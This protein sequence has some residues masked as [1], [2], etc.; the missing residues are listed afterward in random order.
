MSERYSADPNQLA[1]GADAPHTVRYLIARGFVDV[2]EV[3]VDAACGHGYGSR[4][5]AKVASKVIA[6]DKDKVFASRDNIEFIQADFEKLEE[7]PECD[8]FVSIE[9]IEHLADPQKFLD[10]ITK[11]TRKKIIISSPD[12]H[13]KH[14]H[15]FHLSDVLKKDL[16]RM[17]SKYPDWVIYHGI[18]QGYIYMT[19]F[20][21][22][23]TKLL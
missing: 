17:M 8:T 15:V 13:T 6:M 2:G 4:L 11:T 19:F 22:K 10:K 18:D 21:K 1:R 5:L 20:I 3:V 9:S 23:G 14:L 7:F 16:H 12:K